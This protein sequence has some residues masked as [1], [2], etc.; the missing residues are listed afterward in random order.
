MFENESHASVHSDKTKEGLSLFGTLNGTKTTLGRALLRT[1]LLRPSLSLSVINDRH[2]AVECFMRLENIATGTLMHSH[3]KGIKNMPRILSVLRTGRG[4][5]ADWQGFVKFTFHTTMLRDT[6]MELRHANGV[7]II[8][9]LMSALDVVTFKEIGSRVNDIVDWEESAI[10]GRVC[11]RPHIDEE[12]DNRKHV[13]NG[14]DSVLSAV[15][16]QLS[17]SVSPD[18]APFLN[19][20]Y[21]PQLGYL[22]CIPMLDEWQ[23]EAGI[24][25]IDGWTFQFSSD[26]HV[27]FKSQEMQDMDTHIGDLHSTIVDRELEIIQDLLEEVLVVDDAMGKACDVCA[28]ADCLLSFAEASRLYDY[29]RPDMVQDNYIEI[30]G[31][32]H[33]LHE[34]VVDT[35]VPN[36]ARILGGA[37]AGSSPSTPD[38]I[39]EWNSVILCT[40]AN[41]CGKSVYLKQIAIIQIMAQ[42]GWS[43]KYFAPASI[44][45]T[46]K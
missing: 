38:D 36:N 6:L 2:E 33:P 22:I 19:V 26:A 13:Y 5:L 23:G 34:Q 30:I 14:I 4:K 9:K 46:A 28:E 25:A 31:G 43:V 10:A 35:F 12:L 1:W 18:I 29:K 20:V 11:V 37:G 17:E 7:D 32:R 8:K 39:E 21:F 41:A 40:G 3:L 45:P 44:V 42:I 24:Q 16:K 27:Y 15:A